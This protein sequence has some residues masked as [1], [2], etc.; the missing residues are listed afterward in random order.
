[1]QYNEYADDYERINQEIYRRGKYNI[2]DEDSY[3][4]EFENYMQ[5]SGEEIK[6]D[7][8]E[9]Y[10]KRHKKQMNEVRDFKQAGGKDLKRDRR[11]TARRTVRDQGTY[12]RIGAQH[13]DKIGVDT[14]RG[15][16]GKTAKRINAYIFKGTIKN[17]TVYGKR[18]RYSRNGRTYTRYRDRKGRFIK[19]P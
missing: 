13:S 7:C 16:R 6:D 11:T 8:Y 9:H 17:K 14:R 5:G 3:F 1:M 2:Y 12:E 15:R 19:R 18:E 10:E 4:K